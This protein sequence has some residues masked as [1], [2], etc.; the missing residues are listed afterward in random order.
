M[1]SSDL[2]GAGPA[3]SSGGALAF[4]PE[5][6][7]PS[8]EPGNDF[9]S[10]V[11]QAL[12]NNPDRPPIPQAPQT[13]PAPLLDNTAA[14]YDSID[15]ADGDNTLDDVPG[16]SSRQSSSTSA[17]DASSSDPSVLSTIMA[18]FAQPAVPPPEA[19][20]PA[21]YK[22]NAEDLKIASEQ[23]SE[24]ADGHGDTAGLA[25][26]EKGLN[27]LS[28][29]QSQLAS[30]SLKQSAPG[31]TKAH[32]QTEKPPPANAPPKDVLAPPATSAKPTGSALQT[33]D[34]QEVS[35]AAQ[36]QLAQAAG[37]DG[38][39]TA[40]NR[41]RMKFV[42]E[43]NEIA[44]RTVQ[45]LPDGS[46]S[47][48]T[49]DASIGTTGI[50]SDGD[51]PRR[52]R[53]SFEPDL[54][55]NFSGKNTSTD[56]ALEKT[57]E[58]VQA[59]D[60]AGSQVERLTHLIGQEVVTVRQSGASSLAVSLKVDSQTELFLQ[61]T[62]HDGQLQASLRCERGNAEALNSHWGQ[63]QE[64]LS[65]QN[66]HLLPLEDKT[67][68]RN[69]GSAPTAPATSSHAFDE[70]FKNHQRQTRDPHEEAP[71][72]QTTAGIRT[73]NKSQSNK[74]TRKGWESWA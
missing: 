35:A 16:Y 7:T 50:K 74:R 17:N 4:S 20:K 1:N 6:P 24:K 12:A 46:A 53:D 8:Q 30:Q 37:L 56:F 27:S 38:T 52:A 9:F 10:M 29:L 32:A 40:L 36:D 49:S 5:Y 28:P 23:P 41:Q 71:P 73:A 21:G 14:D 11:S 33:S 34:S 60:S 68:V 48:D 31:A 26:V 69:S 63:L 57:S 15:G 44:G 22:G 66:V 62:H 65:R 59:P 18:L 3:A 19:A 67:S 61:L 51:L 55:I 42:S 45:K 47:A 25:S 13:S 43:K 54:T 72:A 70:S 64:S 2:F 39:A 58:K